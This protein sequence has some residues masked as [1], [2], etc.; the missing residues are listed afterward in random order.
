MSDLL[1]NTC[2]VAG[3]LLAV[4]IADAVPISTNSIVSVQRF[5]KG[6]PVITYTGDTEGCEQLENFYRRNASTNG[7]DRQFDV[8]TLAI[9]NISADPQDFTQLGLHFRAF[10]VKSELQDT[11][12]S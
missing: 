5:S 9:T 2:E 12:A 3:S 7:F 8:T 10:H 6:E 4:G 11:G 1:F